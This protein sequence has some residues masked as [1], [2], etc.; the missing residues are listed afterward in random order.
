MS[1][2]V[3][4]SREAGG[5]SGGFPGWNPAAGGF[6]G[7]NPAPGG[8]PGCSPAPGRQLGILLVLHLFVVVSISC[9]SPI[10]LLL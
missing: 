1:S 5:E 3:K 10:R 4:G 8:F 9:I 6:P 7:W 2:G